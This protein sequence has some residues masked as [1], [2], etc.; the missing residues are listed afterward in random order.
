M[1]ADIGDDYDYPGLFARLIERHLVW[2]NHTHLH[3]A[4]HQQQLLLF[5]EA[6]FESDLQLLGQRTKKRLEAVL[7]I[8][9]LVKL[10]FLDVSFLH[11]CRLVGLVAFS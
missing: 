9:E 5:D 3:I 1:Q 8:F 6:S 2:R 7:C 11:S 10:I 4:I